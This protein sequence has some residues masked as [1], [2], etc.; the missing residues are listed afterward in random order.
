MGAW[1]SSLETPPSG[2]CATPQLA[3]LPRSTTCSRSSLRT[4]SDRSPW[5]TTAT[6]STTGRQWTWGR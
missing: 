1:Q 6:S 5:R 3:P 4:G 2:T